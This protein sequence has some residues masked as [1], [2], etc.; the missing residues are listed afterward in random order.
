METE[1]IKV[2]LNISPQIPCTSSI[3]KASHQQRTLLRGSDRATERT[4]VTAPPADLSTRAVNLGKVRGGGILE[5]E[6]AWNMN[7]TPTFQGAKGGREAQGQMVPPLL[8]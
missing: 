2:K 4:W 8:P 7:P 1:G 5:P 3:W 6:L